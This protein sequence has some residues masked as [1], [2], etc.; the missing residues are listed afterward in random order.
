MKKI[1]IDN[2][3][4]EISDESYEAFK[5]QFIEPDKA[6]LWKPE[7]GERYRYI[8]S[9]GRA[10]SHYFDNDWVDKHYYSI[11]NM[12][13]TE[14]EAEEALKTGW[15]AKRQAEVKILRYIAEHDLEFEP[16]WED[17]YENKYSIYYSCRRE[18]FD[19]AA[20]NIHQYYTLPYFRTEEDAQ[21]VID[22]CE[23]ELRVLFGV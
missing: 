5:K 4:I 21:Q 19:V 9:S 6:I 18:G 10:L 16:D 14:E 17:E 11:G 1:T 3:T 13:K 22:N 7:K 15:V 23:N 2:K 12:F 20:W 8:N